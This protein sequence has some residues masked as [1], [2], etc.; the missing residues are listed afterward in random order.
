MFL[1]NKELEVFNYNNE[2]YTSNKIEE[3]FDNLK[4]DAEFYIKDL[5][6]MI[7]LSKNIRKSLMNFKNNFI[8][9][10]IWQCSLKE[11]LLDTIKTM[12][13]YQMN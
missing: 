8:M 3:Y 6:S 10:R 2:P 1:K 5:E 11:I 4:R 13:P 7:V 12:I 9:I